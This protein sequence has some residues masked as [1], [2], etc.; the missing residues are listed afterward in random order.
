MKRN[1][2][3]CGWLEGRYFG[4]LSQ[5]VDVRWIGFERRLVPRYRSKRRSR[6]SAR[7]SAIC[8]LLK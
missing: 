1:V 6:S 2:G 3:R 7:F 8:M 5:E 4:C